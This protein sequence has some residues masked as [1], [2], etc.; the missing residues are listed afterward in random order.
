MPAKK[1]NFKF[2]LEKA[3]E[4]IIYLASKV[5]DPTFLRIS[6]LLYF[7]DKTSLERYAR[8][9]TGDTYFAMQHGPVPSSAY[10]LMKEAPEDGSLGFIREYERTIK[11]C[12]KPK[13]N[14]LS[15]SDQECLDI[16]VAI[17]GNAPVWKL[18]Q[19]SHDEAYEK[20]WK[21]RGNKS[22]VSM[23]LEK[24]IELLEDSDE[25]LEHFQTQHDG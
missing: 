16:A 15:D 14:E 11:V 3:I 1:L 13:L 12:R 5:S 9:I 24:I 25:L 8:F 4:V 6:K 23:P 7:A 20:A 22:S 17:W 10:N 2:N 21:E 19:D 18:I